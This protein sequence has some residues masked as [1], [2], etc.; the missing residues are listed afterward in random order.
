MVLQWVET[1]QFWL[2]LSNFLPQNITYIEN[3]AI[4]EIVG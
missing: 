2:D 3:K 4:H 1:E